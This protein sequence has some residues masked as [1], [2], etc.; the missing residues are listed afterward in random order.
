[1][2][3]KI[4]KQGTG[5][6]YKRTSP[7]GKS[8]IGQTIY[9]EAKRWT[10]H[11]KDAKDPKSSG[12]KSKLS[13]AIRKYGGE[14]F[15][16]EILEENIPCDL[17]GIKEQYYI[18]LYD[19]YQ[20]GYNSTPGGEGTELQGFFDIDKSLELWDEGYGIK[21]IAAQLGCS[22]STAARYLKDIHNISSEK[23]IS[24]REMNS[25]VNT[26]E[27]DQ[28]LKKLYEEG[29]SIAQLTRLW[30]CSQSA[31][32]NALTRA[33]TTFRPAE[34]KPSQAVCQI[35]LKTK[36]VIQTFPSCRAAAR[37]MGVAHGNIQLVANHQHNRTSS[38]G[39][40]WEWESTLKGENNNG[41]KD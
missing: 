40:G 41:E 25:R 39:F 26:P 1:M 30:G 16:V 33:G 28:Q 10:Q 18:Q 36:Q 17:L 38:C 34:G 27:E 19:T 21:D 23:L 35:D 31:I 11:I 32:Y 6:I 37:A 7:S 14:N 3:K 24:R 13:K 29:L 22:P 2:G 12:Y 15:S 4:D 8:Y 5:I 9:T 20:T